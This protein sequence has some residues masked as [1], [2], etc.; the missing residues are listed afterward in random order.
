M[1]S[2]ETVSLKEYFE[3]IL[4][5]R[6]KKFDADI[7]SAKEAVT[8]A[9]SSAKEVTSVAERN[10]EKWRDSA[11]EWRAAMNDKDA[12]FMLKSEFNAYKEATE[13]ALKIQK[14]KGDVG[15]GKSA[16]YVQIIGYILAIVAIAIAFLKK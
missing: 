4:R 6:D 8:V 14:E 2:Q 15:A 7:A 12:N 16:G 9:L 1:E 11:N 10:A 13:L 3:A 5:E